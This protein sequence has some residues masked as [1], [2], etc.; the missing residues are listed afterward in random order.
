MKQ[1]ILETFGV[2]LESI[3][4]SNEFNLF[5]AGIPARRFNVL[6]NLGLSAVYSS[7]TI[8]EMSLFES[9]RDNAINAELIF[10]IRNQTPFE[11]TNEI[12]FQV[13]DL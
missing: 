10:E 6:L 3:V 7:G 9:I 12:I 4:L 5:N 2:T 1:P 8:S 13:S 11:R